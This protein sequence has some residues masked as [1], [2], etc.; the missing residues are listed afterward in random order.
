[1]FRTG[2]G[3]IWLKWLFQY[4][5]ARA[6]GGRVG[7]EKGAAI[8]MADGVIVVAGI[9]LGSKGPLKASMGGKFMILRGRCQVMDKS[10]LEESYVA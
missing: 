8:W 2:G 7:Y 1:M 9:V 6:C 5:V 4:M 10:R 3:A